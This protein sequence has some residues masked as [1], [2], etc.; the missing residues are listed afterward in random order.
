MFI[1]S[2]RQNLTLHFN[3]LAEENDI[4]DRKSVASPESPVQ[5]TF[6]DPAHVHNA[7]KNH[8][9]IGPD[10][11]PSVYLSGWTDSSLEEVPNLT[12]R[13]IKQMALPVFEGTYS[14]VYKGALDG[15]TLV[16]VPRSVILRS[17]ADHHKVAIKALRDQR[18]TTEDARRVSSHNTL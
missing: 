18:I 13:V 3:V 17:S 2:H 15:D 1:L 10:F 11:N 7:S 5:E 9:G 12:G 14:N 4:A 8:E 16:R 6:T